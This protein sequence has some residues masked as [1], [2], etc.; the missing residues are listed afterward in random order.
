M[1]I[2]LKTALLVAG[3]LVLTSCS[4][5]RGAAISTEIL[6]EKN[7]ETPTIDVVPVGGDNVAALAKWP[8]TGWHGHYHWLG[9]SRGPVS[10]IIG[11]GDKI[12]LVIWDSQDNSLLTNTTSKTV[13]MPGL[14]VSPSGSIFVP[15]LEDITVRGL[16]PSNA[17]KKIQKALSPIVP[18]A[19]VQLSFA[20][21]QGNSV[22]LVSGVTRPG[23]YPLPGRNYTILSL[24][25]QG[26]GISPALRNPLVRLMRGGQTFEI[27]ADALFST[28]SKNTLL[29]GNDKILVQEDDRYFTALGATGSEKLIYFEKET[30]TAL[31]ALSVIGGI[32]DARADPKGVLVLREYPASAVRSD[33]RGP[34]LRN[35]VFSFDLTTADGLFAARSFQ[36]N[37]RDTVLATESPVTLVQTIFGLFGSALGIAN[38]L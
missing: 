19:Q 3:L 38:R 37:P 32:S 20:A 16:T 15:Y 17:R 7:N 28:A 5:P 35:V 4:L 26:G 36:I 10:P 6:R 13:A 18:D 27:R 12:D 2:I 21:G 34:K 31:E 24:I 9:A 8:I 22:D 1:R 11:A 14:V 30:L 25:A 29:R 23:T 33:G